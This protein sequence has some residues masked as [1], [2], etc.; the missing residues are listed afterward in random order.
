MLHHGK[1]KANSCNTTNSKFPIVHSTRIKD[2][3]L[4]KQLK[5]D[6]EIVILILTIFSVITCPKK[7]LT[8]QR[9]HNL[10]LRLLKPVF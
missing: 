2:T 8:V 10:S 5:L 9:A 4:K 3:T 7:V 6:N 1:G